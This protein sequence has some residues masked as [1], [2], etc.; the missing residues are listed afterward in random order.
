M[1][2]ILV[3]KAKALITVIMVGLAATVL[4][5]VPPVA[6]SCPTITKVLHAVI[7][8]FDSQKSRQPEGHRPNNMK[9]IDFSYKDN[10]ELFICEPMR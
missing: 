7:C 9:W 3:I 6:A 10:V 2:M 5:V 4:T 8:F 1:A